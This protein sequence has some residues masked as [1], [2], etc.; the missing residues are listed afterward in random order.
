[1][2]SGKQCRVDQHVSAFTINDGANWIDFYPAGRRCPRRKRSPM[3]DAAVALQIR[4]DLSPPSTAS[5]SLAAGPLRA[6]EKKSQRRRTRRP[7]YQEKR[8]VRVDL[9][10]LHANPEGRRRTIAG[11]VGFECG[12]GPIMRRMT[13]PSG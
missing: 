10:S 3:L 8:S 12:G 9:G 11:L 1:M 2:P 4:L 7:A 6:R 5:A 13:Q